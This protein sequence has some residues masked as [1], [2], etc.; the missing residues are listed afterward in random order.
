MLK[1]TFSLLLLL[2]ATTTLLG[3]KGAISGTVYDENGESLPAANVVIEGTTIG[4]QTDFIEGKYQFQADPGVYTIVATYLG[5][6][7][8]KIEGVE[9]KANETVVLDI[10]F[11]PDAAGGVDLT[12][13]VVKAAALERGEVAVL[14]LRQN[15]VNAKDIISSQEIKSLGVGTVSGALTKVTGTTVVDGKYVYVRGLGDRYSA[16]TLNGLRLPSIDPYRN[17]AQLDLIPTSILDNISASKTFTPDLPGDFTGGSVDV[18]IKA[19]PER[20]TW[21]V[22]ASAAYN[23]QANLRDDFLSYDGANAVTLGY[24][25]NTFAAPVDVSDP[26]FAELGTLASNAGRRARRDDALAASLEEV[27]NSF[28]NGFNIFDTDAGLDWSLS[29]NIGNQFQLGSMPLGVFATVSASQDFSQYNNGI[30]GNYVNPGPGSTALQEVFDLRDDKSTKSG[31]VGGMVGFNLRLSPA[32]QVSF[33]T[34]YS[35]QGYAEAR[36]LQGSNESKGASG[37]PDNNYI[38]RASSFLE[39]E[40]IDYVLQGEHT[41]PKLNNARI[42]WTANLVNTAQNEPDLRFIEYIDQGTSIIND[43]SQFSRPSRFFR[44][45]TD[46]SYAGKIDITLPFLQEQNR[47][48]NIKFG[49]QLRRKERDFNETIFAFNNRSGQTL[50]Q[51]G[52]DFDLFFGADNTGIIGGESGRNE[53]GVYAFNNTNPANSYVGTDEVAAA[54]LMGTYQVTEWLKVTG[55]LRAENTTIFVESDI[56]ELRDSADRNNFIAD[57]DTL[58]FMPA[59]NFVISTRENHNLRFGFSQTV[60]RPN[61]REVAPF[62]SFGFFGDP[63]VFGNPDLELT[64]INNFDIRYE[65]FPA[66]NKGE[67]IS[68]S[69]F[70]KQF[71]NPIVTTFRLSGEQQFTWENTASA[72]LYGLELEL[73]KNLGF[74]GTNF[75]N[76]TFSSN[77]AYIQSTQ[78]VDEQECAIG[79]ELDPDFECDR[80]FNGQSDFVANANLSYRTSGDNP[81]DAIIAYNYFGD[82]LESIGAPGSPDIFE[83]GRSQLDVSLSKKVNNFKLSLRMRNLLDP[84]FKTFSEFNGEEYI[85]SQYTRGREI[86]FGVS[87]GL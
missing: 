51:V 75:S 38:S 40:L 6:A 31:N 79:Q 80:R 47:A 83:Q 39:R 68:A 86:S 44:D 81:W 34:L 49:G 72:D 71:V 57:I 12:E 22:S 42:E 41:L 70:Y 73:R 87:Y 23:N 55:G 26:R 2:V 59:V 54:Y 32:N 17:S 77:F 74:L 50:G 16:T 4:T 10:V 66:T 3:Q 65:I 20:F 14:K 67:V 30:R 15:D 43:P 76:F 85:F 36:I 62:G 18:K 48:N 11:D 64:S 5:Y 28:G 84:D 52:G 69:A 63:P 60:A 21:G 19:L 35:H 33:Y 37:E 13:V 24:P 61:M 9:V 29:A 82:R 46:Q 25:G 8:Q 56:A 1:H 58:N 27:A 78:A 45:L 53:I 7:D